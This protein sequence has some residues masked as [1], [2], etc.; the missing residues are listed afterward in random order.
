MMGFARVLARANAQMQTNPE[1][2][3][4]LRALDGR[5]IAPAPGGDILRNPEAMPT[6][7]TASKAA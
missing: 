1:I 5:F 3:A 7:R 2:D 6:G 4:V